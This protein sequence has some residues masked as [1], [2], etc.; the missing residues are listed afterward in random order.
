MSEQE[1]AGRRRAVGGSGQALRKTSTDSAPPASPSAIESAAAAVDAFLTGGEEA[2]R[3]GAERPSNPATRMF[4]A[5]SGQDAERVGRDPQA[6][7][8]GLR[9]VGEDVREIMR[10]AVSG[11]PARHARA[12]ARL[13]ELK[14]LQAEAGLAGEAS[15]EAAAPGSDADPTVPGRAFAGACRRFSRRRSAGSSASRRR[16][17]Q[18]GPVQ[19]ARATTK[20]RL[21]PEEDQGKKRS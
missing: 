21:G 19:R 8:T 13:A 15:P 6:L 4:A 18:P 10:D 2:P 3:P 20:Q 12:E 14:R 16:S 5:W 17:K 1:N 7:L 11:D 9:A